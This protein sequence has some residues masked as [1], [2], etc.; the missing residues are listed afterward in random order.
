MTISLVQYL[1]N[2]LYYITARHDLTS[3]IIKLHPASAYKHLLLERVYLDETLF[4]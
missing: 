2:H 1:P 4:L 3:L